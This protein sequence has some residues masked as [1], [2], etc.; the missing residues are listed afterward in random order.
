MATKAQLELMLK[1]ANNRI[2]E[3]QQQVPQPPVK[4]YLYYAYSASAS[5][6]EDDYTPNRHMWI[7]WLMKEDISDRQLEEAGMARF[8]YTQQQYLQYNPHR[9]YR[10]VVDRLKLCRLDTKRLGRVPWTLTWFGHLTFRDGRS[11]DELF[12][13]FSDYVSKYAWMQDARSMTTGEFEARYETEYVCLMGA[14]DRWR[15]QMCACADCQLPDGQ[16]LIKH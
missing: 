13:S 3:L 1:D 4:D 16:V 7:N 5:V 9:S 8:A 11:D 12:D 15:W 14:E 10:P 6:L 2:M